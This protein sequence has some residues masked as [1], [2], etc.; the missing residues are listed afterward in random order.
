MA[1]S[2]RDNPTVLGNDPYGNVGLRA[3]RRTFEDGP[4]PFPAG[5]RF[6]TGLQRGPALSESPWTVT[7]RAG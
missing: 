6:T 2:F 5:D 3:A 1:K 4:F 7:L